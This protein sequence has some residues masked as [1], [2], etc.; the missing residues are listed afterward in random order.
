V[1]ADEEEGEGV[2]MNWFIVAY[3]VVGI[4]VGFSYFFVSYFE[5]DE[6]W[7]ILWPFAFIFWPSVIV[8]LMY[9][10]IRDYLAE[11]WRLWR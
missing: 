9:V 11:V 8:V 4:V 7:H 2:G 1:V 5:P 3:I 6:R 10:W